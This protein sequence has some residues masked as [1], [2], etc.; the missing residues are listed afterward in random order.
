VIP[1]HA[2]CPSFCL[3]SPR[4]WH[5][6]IVIR[7]KTNLPKKT[8]LLFARYR[9]E[10]TFNQ[11]NE[12]MELLPLNNLYERIRS[13]LE[14]ARK[15]AAIAVNLNIVQAYREV[16]LMIVEEEQQGQDRAAHGK[17]I[18]GYVSERLTQNLGKGFD[19]RNLR[20]MRAFHQTFP[21]WNAVRS[22]LTWTHY[23]L[24]A[25]VEND[26]ARV[27]YVQEAIDCQWNTRTLERQSHSL[28]YERLLGSQERI[29]LRRD[30]NATNAPQRPQDILNDPHILDFLGLP[31]HSKPSE[32]TLEQALIDELRAFMLESD[33]AD[34]GQM[35]MYVRVYQDKV[36]GLD[37]DPA[38][39]LILCAEKDATV[40]RYSVLKDSEQLFA[41]KYKR[42]LPSEA[43][44]RQELT[45]EMAQIRLEHA[46]NPLKS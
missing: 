45:R 17:R 1:F 4:Y 33:H 29:A 22:E 11:K 14:D 44:L 36:R 13:A 16:G 9:G 25:R 38:I 5:K 30:E 41:A 3:N 21:N 40:V 8:S 18:L 7:A 24:L 19:E 6:K 2:N 12:T 39:G 42:Y 20:F 46:L 34:I 35:D 15:R 10:K 27:F 26:A 43:G 28:Y 31:T 37:D 23:R 32:S